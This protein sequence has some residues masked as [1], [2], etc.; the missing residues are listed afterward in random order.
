[1]W[2]ANKQNQYID[3]GSATDEL[4]KGRS[5]RDYSQP[6][7]FYSTHACSRYRKDNKNQLEVKPKRT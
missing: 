3:I 2:K 6:G 5:T 7:T 1:M 4:L